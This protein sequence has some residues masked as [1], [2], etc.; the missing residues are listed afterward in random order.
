MVVAAGAGHG[1]ALHPA[2]HDIDAVV[3]DV[4]LV[5]QEAATQ[6]QVAERGEVAVVL[7]GG[8]LVGRELELEEAVVGQVAVEGGDDPVAVGVGVGVAAL[9]LEDVALGVG[10]ACDVEPV[11][12]PAFA[13]GRRGQQPIDEFLDRLRVAVLRERFDLGS[14]RREPPEREVEP[15]GEDFARRLGRER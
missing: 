6:R 4:V 5:V 9:L 11:A 12:S 13:E 14:R 8:E 10:V 15:A 3:D 2:H 7:A 1:Q